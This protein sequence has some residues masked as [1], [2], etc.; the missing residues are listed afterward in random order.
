M[1]LGFDLATI[2]AIAVIV[3]VI[4]LVASVGSYRRRIQEL[5]EARAAEEGRR[6][7]L[8]TTY[9]RITEQVAPFLETYPYEA[10]DF[11]FLGTPVDGVQ[12]TDD[13]VVFV[14]FKANTS[15]LSPRQAKVKRLVEEGRVEWMTFRMDASDDDGVT[16]TGPAAPGG[17]M[18]EM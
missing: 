12:F 10:R 18:D 7:S 6:R 13:K 5:E 17:S 3:L 14:E 4:A 11:R 9:G 16:R 1:P 2:L 8:S 15:R